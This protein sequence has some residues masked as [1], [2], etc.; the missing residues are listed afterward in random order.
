MGVV[1]SGA[2]ALEVQAL[3]AGAV[4]DLVVHVGVEGGG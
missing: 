4:A 3:A 2:A 1:V